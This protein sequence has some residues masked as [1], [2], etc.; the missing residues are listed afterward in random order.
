VAVGAALLLAGRGGS[1]WQ[2]FALLAV[3]GVGA[4]GLALWISPNC[5]R[6]PY[7]DLDPGLMRILLAPIGEAMPLWDWVLPLRP[8]LAILVLPVAGL[9]ALLIA[10]ASTDGEERR[11]WLLL[12]AFVLVAMLVMLLQVRGTRLASIV[13][14][15]AAAWLVTRGWQRFRAAQTLR[16]AFGFVLLIIPF[17]GMLHWQLGNLALSRTE[18]VVGNADYESAY[19]ACTRSNSYTRLAALPASRI[20]AYMIIGHKILYSTPHSVVASGYHRNQQ[21]L[22]DEVAFFGGSEAEARDVATRRGL[23][24]LVTCRGI[25][26][27]DSLDGLPPFK[28]FAWSWLTPV[29]GADEPLQIYRISLPS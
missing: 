11:R 10:I 27:E 4:A 13:T 25:S 6:G 3:F 8:Q 2:R 17:A 7:G 19:A 5:L 1:A 15:P 12:G 26:P 16:A 9:V 18:A 23:D 28:G 24:Y 20:I 21:G 14:L 22:K 29:S